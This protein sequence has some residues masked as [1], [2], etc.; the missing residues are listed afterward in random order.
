MTVHNQ[1]EPT[2]FKLSIEDDEEVIDTTEITLSS[3][4]T[5]I[6]TLALDDL[7]VNN[8]YKFVAEGL[9]GTIF[10]NSSLLNVE[11]KNCSLFIQSDKGIYK[12]GESIQFRVLVLDFDLK[13]VDLDESN[14]KVF[15]MVNPF[16]IIFE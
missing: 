15:V 9:S 4:E 16:L 10:K 6:V 5:Q 11:S 7:I 13:P 3:N 2:A 1:T 14:L 8:N 12:P